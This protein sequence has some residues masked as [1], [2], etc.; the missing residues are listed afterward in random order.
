[1]NEQLNKMKAASETRVKAEPAAV[2]R[3]AV[4]RRLYH[5]TLRNAVV[6]GGWLKRR[7][8]VGFPSYCGPLGERALPREGRNLLVMSQSWGW[9]SG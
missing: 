7:Q 9:C 3:T 4:E 1:M 8:D 2:G 6:E 5:R